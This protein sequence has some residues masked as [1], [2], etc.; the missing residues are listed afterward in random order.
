MHD[1]LLVFFSDDFST[2]E[3]H[4]TMEIS[5]RTSW[6]QSYFVRNKKLILYLLDSA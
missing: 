2:R 6:E 3:H 4:K 5:Q 1:E